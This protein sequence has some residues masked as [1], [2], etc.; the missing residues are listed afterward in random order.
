MLSVAA[1][2]RVALPW[3]VLTFV[4]YM[5]HSTAPPCDSVSL[6]LPL[7]YCLPFC[8]RSRSPL[9]LL[10]GS[11][12]SRLPLRYFTITSASGGVP[13]SFCRDLPLLPDHQG[14]NALN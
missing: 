5:Y 8:Y 11:Q 13:E 7:F 4:V 6:W 3:F 9:D 14:V 1:G 2:R 12:V 10:L